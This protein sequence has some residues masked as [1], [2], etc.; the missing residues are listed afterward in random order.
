MWFA[1][2]ISAIAFLILVPAANGATLVEIQRVS[3]PLGTGAGQF[4]APRG[5][6]VNRTGAGGVAAGDYYVADK[7]SSP[8]ADHRI[9]EF[10]ESGTFVRAWGKDVDS[11]GGSG[12][13]VC[14][15]AANCQAGAPGGE[16]GALNFPGGIAIDQTTGNVYVTDQNNNRIDIYAATGEFEGAFGWKV[17]ASAPLAELQFCTTATGCQAGEG[18]AAAGAF[19]AF[20]LAGGAIA[21]DPGNGHIWVGDSTNHRIDEFSPELTS[22][23]VTGVSFVRALGWNIDASAP[24]E[25]LQECTLLTGCKTGTQGAGDGQI[26]E[27]Q[28][29]AIDSTGD[30]FVSSTTVGACSASVPCRVFEFDPSGAFKEVFGPGSGG[31]AACQLNWNSGSSSGE[32]VF[33]I[34][35]DPANQHPF[36]ARKASTSSLS[37]C[38]FSPEGD[39]LGRSPTTPIPVSNSTKGNLAFGVEEHLYALTTEGTGESPVTILGFIPAAPAVATTPTEV[40]ANCATLNGEVTVPKPGGPGFNVSYHFEYS[41][42]NGLTW[43][44]APDE[45]EASVGTTVQGTY[46]VQQTVCDLRANTTYRVR[47]VTVT[48]V[49]T[50]SEEKVFTTSMAAPGISQIRALDATETTALLEATIDPNGSATSYRF[51]WGSTPEYGNTVPTG[52]EPVIPSGEAVKVTAKLSGLV[53]GGVY[54]YRVVATNSANGTSV[55]RSADQVVESLNSCGLPEERCFEMVSP[56]APGPVSLPG[57]AV[58]AQE[59]VAQAAEAPGALA[60]VTELG[61]PDATRGTELLYVGSRSPG[62]W[63]SSQYSPPLEEVVA[64]ED[65]S[66][67]FGLSPNLTCG[68]VASA[69]LLTADPAA[70]L[71]VEA[72]GSNLYRR[73][74]DGTYTLV[75]NVAPEQPVVA[76]APGF[77]YQLVGMSND[78]THIYFTSFNHYPGLPSKGERGLYEWD[79]GVLRAL[80]LIPGESGDEIAEVFPGKAEHDFFPNLYHVVSA[81]GARVFFSAKRIIGNVPGE[82]GK[83]GVFVHTD[84]GSTKDVSLSHTAVPDTGAEFQGATP[85]GLHVYFLANAGL[86]AKTSANGTDLY[87]YDLSTDTLT[88]LSVAPEPDGVAEAGAAFGVGTGRGSLLGVAADGSHVYFIARGRLVP[89]KGLSTAQ[90]Q[91]DNTFS[92]YDYDKATDTV[93]FVA[94]VGADVVGRLTQTIGQEVTSRV[95]GDGRYLLFESDQNVTGYESGGAPEAYLYDAEAVDEPVVCISCRQDGRP[96]SFSG[97]GDIPLSWPG[98]ANLLAPPRS[99][100]VRDGKPLVFFE[101]R[102]SLARGAVEGERNLYEWAH[103]QVFHIAAEM[104]GGTEPGSG[105]SSTLRFGGASADGTDVYFF[106]ARALNWE[107]PAARRAAWDARVGGGFPEPPP[108]SRC[109]ATAEGGCQAPSAEAPIPPSAGTANFSGPGNV[110]PNSKQKKHKKRRHH[111]H[112]KKH[113]KKGKG[114]T[115]GGKKQ[116][117]QKARS[118]GRHIKSERGAGK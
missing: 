27:P 96:A 101:S 83:F 71:V 57:S 97:G 43:H 33:S 68:V 54:H 35:I 75:T 32:A 65:P 23:K 92:L 39:L 105:T 60:Y 12:F 53:P 110:Q 16:A 20:G 62:G 94:T 95:S 26:A 40:T 61:L 104:P 78:C 7:S 34:A 76:G 93:T 102:E 113:H 46:P 79:N 29:L 25:Q 99:L 63:Q 86:T 74:G 106:D 36:F 44:R 5:L 67:V 73:N 18:A 48:S 111:H 85:D 88:D 72:G 1:A 30:I 98:Q 114:A 31:E 66:R 118:Q 4:L 41:G 100:V 69:S 91:A 87:E 107:N 103:G 3:G 70:R 37:I 58:S 89:G 49:V 55:T 56:R 17:N 15:V 13:E 52:F 21:V 77:E 10:T 19:G 45:G 50:T 82:A 108:P 81:N 9:Q 64:Q 115:H 28:A 2:I 51:E 42:D 6:A 11:T 117:H 47:L 59:L 24:A 90:N 84:S 22:G 80:S 109:D 8:N 112:K 14:E 116:K 38:E